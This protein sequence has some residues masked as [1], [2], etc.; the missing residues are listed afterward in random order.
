MR[1]VP[2]PYAFA[3]FLL[4]Y[5]LSF[6]APVPAVAFEPLSVP[7]HGP[8]ILN[9]TTGTITRSF[10]CPSTQGSFNLH[11]VNGDG[12]GNGTVSSAVIKVNG[13]RI[14]GQND[15]NANVAQ[16]DKPLTNLVAG[17][18]S[19]T[20]TLGTSAQSS[21]ITVTITGVYTLDVTILSPAEG[22]QIAGTA[23]S[24]SGSY[25]SYAP[26]PSISVNGVAATSTGG[27]FTA[28]GVPVPS[29]SGFLTAVIATPD[30]LSD[31]DNV[32]VNGNHP[33]QAEA[34]ADM[35]ARVGDSVLLDGRNSSDPESALITYGWTLASKPEGSQ[36]SLADNQSVNPSFTPDRSG[37]YV[38]TLIVNDG[39]QGSA[40][41]NVTITA[42]SAPNADAGSDQS[43]V[44]GSQVFL[45]GSGSFDPDLTPITWTWRLAAVPPESSAVLLYPNTVNPTF[46]AD[47]VG[48]YVAELTVFD[49][50][51]FSLPD[52]VSI[53]AATPNAP[54]VAN[55]GPD[56]TVSR[57][58]STWVTGAGSYDPDNDPLS[59]QWS[60]V[61]IPEGSASVLDNATWPSAT[62]VADREGGYVVRLVVDD[63]QATSAPDTVV[64][65]AV[66]DPPVASASSSGGEVTVGT[67]VSLSGV[68]STDANSDTLT[69]LWSVLTAPAGS[70]ASISGATSV[71]ASITPDM[72]GSYTIRLVVN[73]GF[74]DSSPA[75]LAIS[76]A[77]PMVTVPSV[78]G[79]PRTEAEG[80]IATAGLVAAPVTEESSDS[81][82]AGSVISQNPAGG[83]LVPLGSA[84][85][86]A[87]STGPRMVTVPDVSGMTQS[88]ATSTIV[89][90]ELTVGG[91]ADEA[92]WQ[93]PAG[94]V[95]RTTPGAGASVVHGSAVTLVLSTGPIMAAVPDVVL[96]DQGIA[97]SLLN[98]AGFLTGT[99][100]TANDNLV[101]PGGVL[102][103]SPAAGTSLLQGSPVNLVVSIGP[104]AEILPPDPST[105]APLL[106][107]SEASTLADAASFLYSNNPPV[108][109]GVA[110]GTIDFVRAAAIT[111]KA[112]AL[113]NTPV[114][115]AA[116]TISGHPEYGRTVTRADGG[117]D[118]AV[119]GGQTLFVEIR[120]AGFLPVQRQVEVPWQEYVVLP[121]A[122]LTA[123]DNQ[124]TLVDLSLPTPIQVARGSVVSDSDGVRQATLFVSQGTAA[125][126]KMADG[127]TRPLSK[128]SVRATE[129]TVGPNGQ[130]AMPA[131]LPPATAYTYCVD[132][133]VDEA[134][135][136]GATEVTFSKTVYGYVENFIGIPV[137][138][139]VPS[140]Y[141][142]YRK[143]AW[144]PQPAGK[145]IKVLSITGGM[146][147]LDTDGN[148]SIDNAAVLAALGFTDA[149]R[150]KLAETYAAGT[151]LWRVPLTHFSPLDWNYA[152]TLA[153]G[154]GPPGM[155]APKQIQSPTCPTTE[156][157]SIVEC[158]GQA[159]G[160]R[161]PVAGAPFDLMYQSS[162]AEGRK[163]EYSLDISLTGATLPP[164]LQRVTLD[165][166]VAGKWSH[167]EFPA[168]ANQK[169]R[170]TWDGRDS[171]GR[172]VS[173]R[174]MATINLNYVYQGIYSPTNSSN[175]MFGYIASGEALK[176]PTRGQI[177]MVQRWKSPI[178]LLATK[179]VMGGWT[180]TIHHAYD[181]MGKVLHLGDGTRREATD[182]NR[183]VVHVAGTG[184]SGTAGD[185]VV[186]ATAALNTPKSLKAGSDGSLYFAEYGNHK[187]R[188]IG[189]DGRL[190]TIAGTGISGSTVDGTLA[191]VA[192]IAN[193]TALAFD[194]DN[195]LFFS[196]QAGGFKIYRIDNAGK[197]YQ[198][199]THDA[200]I[201]SMSFMP[202][203]VLYFADQ[204]NSLWK[205]STDNA[206]VEVINGHGAS[207]CD[208]PPV[209]IPTAIGDL[210]T[211][212]A[213]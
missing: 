135:S 41:D 91:T 68:G 150:T 71:S 213:L 37:P 148:G 196:Q 52:N 164:G 88:A 160:E 57:N 202:D 50:L 53:V 211:V 139:G 100:T 75:T 157:G 201:P 60:F 79:L 104:A 3:A 16:I 38:V 155:T 55:A 95:I 161:V 145:V 20:V 198:Y 205:L 140:G 54:P 5:F 93:V 207:G 156:N 86:L 2:R 194:K 8:E 175:Q 171:Y 25:A 108:Q 43:V 179:E 65:T 184:V 172:K 206:L 208:L 125:T 106:P 195:N 107:G 96:K 110:A 94:S 21:Y 90:A 78:T 24:V 7:L 118:M 63:G 48:T 69:Y 23:T 136:S 143:S 82:P 12:A 120:K 170:F 181:P 97:Q 133:S 166:F 121:P 177:T 131:D 209:F 77:V 186:A 28:A 163:E 189:P 4:L 85:S 151:K 89:A 197:V 193:P 44:T 33:P 14:V 80:A 190:N 144:I 31:S 212:L 134:V 204:H 192:R 76:A 132:F 114:S 83:T 10:T 188:R 1:Q 123:Y 51:L 112:L 92:S 128:M 152:Y 27:T 29:G 72:A 36:S 142:D 19:F 105:I 137:G 101:M 122:V 146:A 34:G 13:S 42:D 109:T 167:L 6:L 26:N 210:P 70:T 199:Y 183:I 35:S 39:V 173:G 46:V 67:A 64:V 18:N 22:A 11:V 40:P 99:V 56:Q 47:K 162:R 191:T 182:R 169:Y 73:D 154:A 84:V 174:Q 127:S 176:G 111:G 119:N 185:N 187:I 113:D 15:F 117:F 158:E 98:S 102:S 74:V 180:P 200:V 61:S 203:G 32:A 149:E 153:A 141:Y 103:Q 49:G 17:G 116:V 165:V 58:A 178:G 81:V 9:Y 87:V 168:T 45:D 115:G 66:N 147:D 130:R 159:L 138:K 62:F 59:F 129:F 124:V 30:G 126:M